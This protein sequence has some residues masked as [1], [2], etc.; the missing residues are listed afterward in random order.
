MLAIKTDVMAGGNIGI[1]VFTGR[2]ESI[3]EKFENCFECYGTADENNKTCHN[4]CIGNTTLQVA[5][6]KDYW[7]TI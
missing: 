1:P 4:T 2:I 5:L 7:L 6:I 3:K